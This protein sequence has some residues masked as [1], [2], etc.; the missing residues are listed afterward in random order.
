MADEMVAGPAET[1]SGAPAGPGA[2]KQR[3]EPVV[4][5]EFPGFG[6]CRVRLVK[7]G[8]RARAVLDVR[9]FAKGPTFEGFTRRGIRVLT[10]ED[11]TKLR[12]ALSSILE[13]GLLG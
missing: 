12:D 10:K 4:L 11:A 1:G 13:E 7:S 5:R 2:P 6:R 3:P 8:P 9:E